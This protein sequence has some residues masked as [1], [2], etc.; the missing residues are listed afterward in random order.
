MK[1]ATKLL[2]Y[3]AIILIV[4]IAVIALVWLDYETTSWQI[5]LEYS[6]LI[7]G[8][9]F[10]ALPAIIVVSIIFSILKKK[11]NNIVSFVVSIFAGIPLSFA[12]VV[13]VLSIVSV[14]LK[15]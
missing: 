10:Y 4:F 2:P 12:I 13:S 9:I 8:A 6:N 3:A 15:Y 11:I 1:L 14:I 5:A 7:N